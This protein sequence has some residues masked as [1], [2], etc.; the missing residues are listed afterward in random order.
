M[1]ISSDEPPGLLMQASLTSKETG[2]HREFKTRNLY[3][4]LVQ[5]IRGNRMQFGMD[6]P[7]GAPVHRTELSEGKSVPPSGTARATVAP[8]V[9][10]DPCRI[11]AW[12][13]EG[14]ACG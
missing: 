12:E 3:M 1:I 4:E 7:K 9:S 11:E 14:G 6:A 2:M 10:P 13:T 8:T 5:V